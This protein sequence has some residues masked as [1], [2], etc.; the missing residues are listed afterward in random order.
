VSKVAVIVA[1]GVLSCGPKAA[2]D[3][4]PTTDVKPAPRVETTPV[5]PSTGGATYGGA[6][7]GSA[8]TVALPQGGAL[9]WTVKVSDNATN[10]PIA[11]VS[12]TAVE[13]TWDCKTRE[14]PLPRDPDNTHRPHSRTETYGCSGGK[15]HITQLTDANGSTT[16]NLAHSMYELGAIKHKSYFAT[17][18]PDPVYQRVASTLVK[19]SISNGGASRLTEYRL[20]P[21]SALKV[22]TD[23]QAE[24]LALANP[25]VKKCLAAHP[26]LT[27]AVKKPSLLWR[28]QFLYAGA[29]N[30]VFESTVDSISGDVGFLGCWDPCCAVKA[31]SRFE[32]RLT[33]CAKLRGTNSSMRR[34]WD[35]D[36]IAQDWVK[37]QDF[38]RRTNGDPA[39][40]KRYEQLYREYEAGEQ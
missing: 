21:E 34:N 2:T 35:C 17:D 33:E 22:T 14:I 31:P 37:L 16:F 9:G 15:N 11:K 19:T 12:V 36:T 27:H 40:L 39:E 18:F 3:V 6:T 1:L 10:K 30:M 5:A 20:L 38:F 23:A 32:K 13:L 26:Q 28:V 29:N 25:I 7:Y 4:K 8:P 24:T